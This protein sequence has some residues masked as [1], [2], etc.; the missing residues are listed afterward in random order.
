MLTA[1]VRTAVRRPGIVIGLAVILVAYG[2]TV[3]SGAELDVFPEFAP[4]QVSIQ[5]EAPGF[6][7]EQ[8]EILVTKPIEDVINGVNGVAVLRSQ[9][10]QGLSVITVVL[11]EGVDVRQARQL[12]AERLA[13]LAGRLPDSAEPPVLSPLTS[14]SSTVLM[15]GFTSTTRTPM[16]QRTFVDWVV[17][18][19]LLATPG[20]AKVAIFGGEV[21]QLQVQGDPV[22]LRAHGL[23]LADLVESAGRATGVRGAGVLD[24]AT[25][26]IVVRTEGQLLTPEA[27][28][29]SLLRAR[30]GSVLRLADVAPAP[31]GRV[32]TNPMA[33]RATSLPK[34]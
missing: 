6:S 28:G 14:S 31:V 33:T 4:P 26:R 27:L 9:S 18:P 2:I 17:K 22:R 3:V 8:V 13:E 12:L 15:V 20:V 11:Q 34:R 29:Q 21:R 19:R 30:D 24:N 10:I 25:Q 1:L 16:E 5:T 7:P 23:S 32:A